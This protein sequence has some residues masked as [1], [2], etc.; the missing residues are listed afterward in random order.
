MRT[1]LPLAIGS[2]LVIGFGFHTESHAEQPLQR[3]ADLPIQ[4]APAQPEKTVP[5]RPPAAQKG[6]GHEKKDGAGKAAQPPSRALEARPSGAGLFVK[7]A[8]EVVEV[9]CPHVIHYAARL[10][11]NAPEIRGWK[12]EPFNPQPVRTELRFYGFKDDFW[13]SSWEGASSI[14]CSCSS[15][16]EGVQY[17][18][19]LT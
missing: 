15:R 1:F 7:P 3:S 12:A 9:T 6:D 17:R 11:E 10:E 13:G 4:I 5:G 16:G 14:V 8:P 18:Q 2:L 19:R